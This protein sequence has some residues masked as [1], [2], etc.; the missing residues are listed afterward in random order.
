MVGINRD[1]TDKHRLDQYLKLNE[2]EKV[3]FL[4]F[5]IELVIITLK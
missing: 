1:I 5:A 3:R 4:N 2:I